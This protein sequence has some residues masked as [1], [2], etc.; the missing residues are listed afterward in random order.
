M[1]KLDLVI[2]FQSLTFVQVISRKSKTLISDS[3]HS[4]V[5]VARAKDLRGSPRLREPT[6]RVEE[7][8]RDSVRPET[9]RTRDRVE[10]KIGRPS[11]RQ[12][13]DVPGTQIGVGR[14]T[15]TTGEGS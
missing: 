4:S 6:Q 15:Q 14:R 8:D 12:A 5:E 3:R 2:S 9:S 10:F 1:R 11:S 7:L 13:R